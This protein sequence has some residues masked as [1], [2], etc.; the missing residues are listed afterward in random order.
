MAMAPTG[1]TAYR[2]RAAVNLARRKEVINI[3]LG[4]VVVLVLGTASLVVAVL[5]LVV[6]IIELT[7]R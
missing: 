3:E 6:K 2:N 7:R 5:G 1:L 4:T